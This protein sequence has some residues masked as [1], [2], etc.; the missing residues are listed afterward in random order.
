MNPV[1]QHLATGSKLMTIG[2]FCSCYQL[3]RSTLYR[4][5]RRRELNVVKCGR[6]SRIVTSEAEAWAENLPAMGAS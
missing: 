1:S 6:A 2:Q 5:V 3:S 4:L